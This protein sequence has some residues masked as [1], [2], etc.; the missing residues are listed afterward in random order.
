LGAAVEPNKRSA[1]LPRNYQGFHVSLVDATSPA[2]IGEADRGVTVQVTKA[3]PRISTDLGK[4]CLRVYARY[5]GRRAQA[6]PWSR[7]VKFSPRQP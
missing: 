5:L 2:V 6:G 3:R 7:H 4:P 1:S